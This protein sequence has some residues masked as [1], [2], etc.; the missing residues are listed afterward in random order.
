MNKR[1]MK[2]IITHLKRIY[3]K[4]YHNSEQANYETYNNSSQT[5]LCKNVS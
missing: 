4:T 5:Y 1:I 2:P 3:V